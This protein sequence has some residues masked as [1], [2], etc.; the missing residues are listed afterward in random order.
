MGGLER[1]SMLQARQALPA[2]GLLGP[3]TQ[4]ALARG[5]EVRGNECLGGGREMTAGESWQA[6]PSHRR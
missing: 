5:Q 6:L 2:A 1:D 3:A 4:M